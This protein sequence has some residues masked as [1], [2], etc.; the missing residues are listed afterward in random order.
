MPV[1]LSGNVS[2]IFPGTPFCL[3]RTAGSFTHP[4]MTFAPA[5]FYVLTHLPHLKVPEGTEKEKI[6]KNQH[7]W[8]LYQLTV[9]ACTE[10]AKSFFRET[11]SLS[12]L[13]SVPVPAPSWNLLWPPTISGDTI[14]PGSSTL[15]FSL[16]HVKSIAFDPPKAGSVCVPISGSTGLAI[17]TRKKKLA[18]IHLTGA[19]SESFLPIENTHLPEAQRLSI[20]NMNGKKY[21]PD[22][23]NP[24]PPDGGLLKV[25]SDASGSIELFDA[26]GLRAVWRIPCSEEVTVCGIVPGT[27]LVIRQGTEAVRVFSFLQDHAKRT[28]KQKGHKEADKKKR[29]GKNAPGKKPDENE[30]HTFLLDFFAD[31]PGAHEMVSGLEEYDAFFPEEGND[32]D[33][34][35]QTAFPA[36]EKSHV[37]IQESFFR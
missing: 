19:A 34:R 26:A 14:F 30:S 28:G 2:L 35:E 6:T 5:I 29:M 3:M 25:C 36:Q 23:S 15:F 18:G 12:L 31:G 20:M 33:D 9:R 24:V 21:D 27:K 13:D 7:G 4:E 17:I 8:T 16:D 10:S 32:P 22:A 1:L 11:F 37:Y